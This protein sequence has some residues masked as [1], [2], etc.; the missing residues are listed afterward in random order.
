[1]EPPSKATCSAFSEITEAAETKSVMALA[2][3]SFS[4]F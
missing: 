1:M 3:G 2:R 4:A